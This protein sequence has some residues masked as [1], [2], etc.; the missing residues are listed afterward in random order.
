MGAA[1]GS[2]GRL[3]SVASP[4]RLVVV[5]IVDGV[6][7]TSVVHL[8]AAERGCGGHGQIVIRLQ[9]LKWAPRTWPSRC[10]TVSA[11]AVYNHGG[12]LEDAPVCGACQAAA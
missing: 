5:P 2:G 3:A 8:P 7:D 11:G 4:D 1:G 6:A 9:D 12:L 10:G